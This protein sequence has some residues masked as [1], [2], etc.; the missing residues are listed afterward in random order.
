QTCALPILGGQQFTMLVRADRATN[1]LAGTELPLVTLLVG[2]LLTLVAAF[3]AR[4][5]VR[6]NHAVGL[7]ETENRALDLAIEQQRRVEAE[8]RASQ[9]RF[10]AMLRDSPDAIALLDIDESACE[11]LNRAT[12]LDHPIDELSAHGGPLQLVHPD[13]RDDADAQF[14]R[15]RQLGDDQILET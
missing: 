10:D 1:A 11:I 8:L 14:D 6:R 7:L 13:D 4:T 3:V 9:A 5:V 12:F 15:L 2:L